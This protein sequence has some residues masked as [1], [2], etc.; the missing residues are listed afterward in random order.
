M[1]LGTVQSSMEEVHGAVAADMASLPGE[2]PPEY[3]SIVTEKKE[4]NYGS[5][6]VEIEGKPYSLQTVPFTDKHSADDEDQPIPDDLID[7]IVE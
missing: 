1:F 2:N 6:D 7:L 4:S 3:S 5:F